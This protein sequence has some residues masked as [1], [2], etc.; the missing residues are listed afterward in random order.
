MICWLVGCC[1]SLLREVFMNSFFGD[2]NKK[3]SALLLG[4]KDWRILAD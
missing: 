3:I 2:E 1:F 4:E